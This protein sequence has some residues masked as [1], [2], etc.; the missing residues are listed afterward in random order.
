[1][2]GLGLLANENCMGSTELTLVC[3]HS[4]VNYLSAQER[5]REARGGLRVT[6]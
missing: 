1:M 4:D 6:R 2:K 3:Q 5:L